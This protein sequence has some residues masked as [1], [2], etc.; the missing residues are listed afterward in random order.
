MLLTILIIEV[1]FI[2]IFMQFA[3]EAD[4]ELSFKE[5][6]GVIILSPIIILLLLVCLIDLIIAKFKDAKIKR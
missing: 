3:E 6:L 4:W 5:F 2:F 1:F